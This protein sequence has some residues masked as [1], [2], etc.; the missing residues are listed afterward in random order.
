MINSNYLRCIIRIIYEIIE[1]PKVQILKAKQIIC[2]SPNEFQNWLIKRQYIL[3]PSPYIGDLNST[4]KN[5]I[6]KLNPYYYMKN[7]LKFQK[8]VM[9]YH[10]KFTK[11]Y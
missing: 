6:M 1:I 8:T 10:K 4:H 2:N 9:N 5:E 11:N 7:N 3:L